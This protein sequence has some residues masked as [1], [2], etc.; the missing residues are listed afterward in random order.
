MGQLILHLPQKPVA[1]HP[2]DLVWIERIEAIRL[3]D[4]PTN[5]PTCGSTTPKAVPEKWCP[6]CERSLPR[7][8]AFFARCRGTHDGHYTYCR[9]CGAALSKAYRRRVIQAG[10]LGVNGRP[11]K[12]SGRMGRSA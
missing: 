10:G 8:P 2:G 6:G 9:P 4:A 1:P 12:L 11:V 5:C 3:E 7:T